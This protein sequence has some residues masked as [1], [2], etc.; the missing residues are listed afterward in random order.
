MTVNSL[1]NYYLCQPI[2][3]RILIFFMNSDSHKIQ[4]GFV[5]TILYSIPTLLDN[6]LSD[7]SSSSSS[8]FFF[9][10]FF[11][12]FL[13]FVFLVWGFSYGINYFAERNKETR[14]SSRNARR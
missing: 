1:F 13:V 14:K 7:S 12:F 4:I 3:R 2:N 11:F 9:F 8:F 6:Y 10:F 5:I